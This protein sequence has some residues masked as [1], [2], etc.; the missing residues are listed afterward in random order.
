MF[1]KEIL[2]RNIPVLK[3]NDSG[4]HAAALMDD[5]KLKHLPVVE[6]GIYIYLLSER[7]VADMKKPEVEI[8]NTCFYAPYVWEESSVLEAL[9][10]MSKDS[11]TLLPVV[12]DN[13]EYAGAITLPVLIESLDEMSNTGSDGALIAVETN[14]QE[15]VLSQMI[16][17]IEDNRAKV[18]SLFSYP[19]KETG[20]LI[21][22]FKIDLEDASPVIRS[23]ERFNYPVKYY[24]QKQM[25]P[26]ETLQN[27]VDELIHYIEL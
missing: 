12:A 16:H 6:N 21:L 4:L 25:L 24:R 8:E 10:V 11:L 9:Q 20:R 22:L 23:L 7:D 26:D 1:C 18:L 19:D 15:F 17:L 3:P 27:R 2:I 5:L 13:G 14:Q